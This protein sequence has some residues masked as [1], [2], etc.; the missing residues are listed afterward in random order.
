M[1]RLKAFGKRHETFAVEMVGSEATI[2]A[3]FAIGLAD[4]CFRLTFILFR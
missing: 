4:V 3:A 2:F 1:F